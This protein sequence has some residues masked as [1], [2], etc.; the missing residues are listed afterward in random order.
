MFLGRQ[1]LTPSQC[2]LA[3]ARWAVSRELSGVQRGF[4]GAEGH[5]L[6]FSSAQRATAGSGGVHWGSPR[7]SGV[8]K[9]SGE[10]RQGAMGH[11]KM[12]LDLFSITAAPALLWRW[13]EGGEEE[14]GQG[15]LGLLQT[16]PAPSLA[17]P[18]CARYF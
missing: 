18:L 14:C 9:G 6:G 16:F 7:C 17:L 15:L 2:T 1:E 3:G 5:A 8:Q 4:G 13:E 12:P 11:G 10:S